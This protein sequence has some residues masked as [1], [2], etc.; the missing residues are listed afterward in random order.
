MSNCQSG[1]G[2]LTSPAGSRSSVKF[3]IVRK[4]LTPLSGV[5][6]DEPQGGVNVKKLLNPPCGV[7][8]NQPPAG[9]RVKNTLNTLSGSDDDQLIGRDNV[10]KSITPQ[11]GVEKGRPIKGDFN[12]SSSCQQN[13]CNEQSPY[14]FVIT[15]SLSPPIPDKNLA[16]AAQSCYTFTIPPVSNHSQVLTAQTESDIV[17]EE[18]Q[19][20]SARPDIVSVLVSSHANSDVNSIGS[21]AI[22][23]DDR[24]SHNEIL[25]QDLYSKKSF[26]ADPSPLLSRGAHLTNEKKFKDSMLDCQTDGVL[27]HGET[28][29]VKCAAS[30]DWRFVKYAPVHE[31]VFGDQLSTLDTVDRQ[32]KSDENPVESGVGNNFDASVRS[33][34]VDIGDS[35]IGKRAPRRRRYFSLKP[36]DMGVKIPTD[37]NPCSSETVVEQAARDNN[38]LLKSLPNLFLES[39]KTN[40]ADG[41]I[42]DDCPILKTTDTCKSNMDDSEKKIADQN[43]RGISFPQSNF[44]YDIDSQRESTNPKP[45]QSDLHS[46]DNAL[47]KN[48]DNTD[49]EGVFNQTFDPSV[50]SESDK[51]FDNCYK[52]V[53][54]TLSNANNIL[55]FDGIM[56]AQSDLHAKE[57]RIQSNLV[58]ESLKQS[59]VMVM[60]TDRVCSPVPIRNKDVDSSDVNRSPAFK[61]ITAALSDV[62]WKLTE[63]KS[64]S[65]DN[66][67]PESGFED[68]PSSQSSP[69]SSKVACNSKSRFTLDLDAF[70]RNCDTEDE[71]SVTDRSDLSSA[72]SEA[73]DMKRNQEDVVNKNISLLSWLRQTSKN[74]GRSSNSSVSAHKHRCSLPDNRRPAQAKPCNNNSGLNYKI[75]LCKFDITPPKKNYLKKM[76]RLH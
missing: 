35:T 13:I 39:N 63:I 46:I 21:D 7:V 45:N 68:T 9:D 1:S 44:I 38:I 24:S 29:L 8:K 23:D 27:I 71:A 74:C 4:S 28:R 51:D 37:T 17:I 75:L 69:F 49:V 36:E 20:F 10:R 18:N 15:K 31:S 16:A 5:I 66:T 72:C 64:I 41:L 52:L 34:A 6:Q 59:S 30:G 57:I 65:S 70:E 11:S 19:V 2:K 25:G 12:R 22:L 73:S 55:P 67:T 53:Q 33:A 76:Y 40:R 54:Q 61:N 26:N 3:S 50:D 56:A 43:T 62:D 60:E 48:F 32:P 58:A 42:G 14:T 47:A